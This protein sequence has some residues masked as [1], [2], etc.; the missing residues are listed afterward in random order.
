MT[1]Y[2]ASSFI[3]LE[4]VEV[5]PHEHCLVHEMGN[6]VRSAGHQFIVPRMQG[7][8][9]G[10]SMLLIRGQRTK[11]LKQPLLTILLLQWLLTVLR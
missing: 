5:G 6:C 8:H 2:G 4:E 10:H 11:F 3:S 1:D 7:K 9:E